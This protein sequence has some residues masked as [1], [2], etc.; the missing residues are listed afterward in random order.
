MQFIATGYN[1]PNLLKA[2]ILNYMMRT[3][4]EWECSIE[5]DLIDCFVNDVAF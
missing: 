4:Y 5:L 2:K 1:K 3:N